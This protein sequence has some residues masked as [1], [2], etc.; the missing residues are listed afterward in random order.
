MNLANT[1]IK[2]NYY[3]IIE[4]L[5][6]HTLHTESLV[7]ENPNITLFFF[8]GLKSFHPSLTLYNFASWWPKDLLDKK[9]YSWLEYINHNYGILEY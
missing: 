3:T 5:R 1:L 2:S 7:C 4:I 6:N 8:V 9:K